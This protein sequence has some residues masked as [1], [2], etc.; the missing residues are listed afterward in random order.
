M[1]DDPASRRLVAK[2]LRSG[3]PGV[4]VTCAGDG[5]QALDVLGREQVD[6]LITDLAMPVV[7]GIELLVQ[8]AR[9][10]LVIPLLVVTGHGSPAAETRALSGG[11]I[12]YFEKPLRAEPFIACILNLLRAGSQGSQLDVVSLAGIVRIISMERKTCALRVTS[13]GA[14]GVLVFASGE[15][16]DAREGELCGLP[17]ALAILARLDASITLDIHARARTRTIHASVTE[18][19]RQASGRGNV[20]EEVFLSS[21]TTGSSAAAT[22]GPRSLPELPPDFAAR[23]GPSREHPASGPAVAPTAPRQPIV[24]PAPMP[25]PAATRPVIAPPR[26]VVGFTPERAHA[27]AAAPELPPPPRLPLR[28]PP[29]VSR[30]GTPPPVPTPPRVSAVPRVPSPPPPA[31]APPR[32]VAPPPTA[33][34]AT[35]P[36]TPDTAVPA[37]PQVLV[38]PTQVASPAAS[39]APAPAVA[40]V[41]DA[42]P[43]AAAVA[44]P[45]ETAIVPAPEQAVVPASPVVPAGDDL[46]PGSDYFELVDHARDLLRVAEFDVAERLLRRALQLRPGDRVVQQN[47]RVLAK[48]RGSRP[49]INH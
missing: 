37:A 49:E 48:R 1:D 42:A 21:P 7:D 39:E 32:V 19:L 17:A 12:E 5:S 27:V 28:S 6:L 16:V 41:V 43:A 14:L 13:D 11:A 9:R 20:G 26:P 31:A 29:L 46:L 30:P 33:S 25:P 35:E 34:V 44:S 15:L 3:V 4:R 8:V 18:V 40:L 23:P 45:P 36:A 24:M 10:R 2:M 38:T 47:L 22:G